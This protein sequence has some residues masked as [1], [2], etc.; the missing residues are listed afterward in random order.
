MN[1]PRR[2]AVVAAALAV[3]L[4][5]NTPSAGSTPGPLTPERLR[6]EAAAVLGT[7]RAVSLHIRVRDG[8]HVAEAGV[9]EA[10]A[11][12]GR[13][14]PDNPH[15]RAASVTKSLVAATVLQLAAE[16]RL[17]L[18]DTVEHWLP[19]R[20]R[21]HGNDGSRITVRHLLQHT[22]GLHDPDST[23]L[24]GKTAPDFERRRFDRV[25]PERLVDIAL[26]H[27]PDFPPA[28]PDDPK[29]RWS[30][31]NTGYH[32]L[33]AVI[34]KATGRPWAEE[35]HERIVRR[36]GLHGTL[37]PGDDPY[38]PEPHARTH[39]R[40]AGSDGYTDTTT[41]NMAWAGPAGSL[42]S[43]PHDLDRFFTALLTGGL[44]PPR[45]LT[46]MRTTVP[47]N[48]EHEQYTPGMRY[49]LGLQEQPLACGGSRWG[50]HGD[51]EG[52][53]V[54]TGFTADGER[55]VVITVSGRDT[56]ETRL[57]RTEKALQGLIDKMLCGR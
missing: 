49:G 7:A 53:F 21:G 52:T 11:G 43:T 44:H 30:Y 28:G 6:H 47:V 57:L 56:D 35:V 27:P 24:T 36:L 37:V 29:P 42:V 5:P 18:N 25:A 33:G 13:P 26:R 2:L 16:R 50:H 55:S 45:E 32:L 20:V 14:V 1:P 10:V 3:A 41:R 12:T 31:S 9:G 4:A 54:R 51:L 40:F 23:E 8:R 15:V 34:E 39:H 46:A 17:S 19:G 38:L 22:S 48:E